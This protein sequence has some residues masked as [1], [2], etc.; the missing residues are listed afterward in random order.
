MISKTVSLSE[1]TRSNT[2]VRFGIDNTPNETQKMALADTA[3]H[4]VDAVRKQFGETIDITSF[5]RSEKLNKKIGGAKGSQHTSGE[6]VDLDSRD[7]AMN[8]AIFNFVK[9][10]LTFDQLILEAPDEKGVPSWVHVSYVKHPKQ[11]RG[12]VLVYL[13][14]SKKYIPFG[15]FQ[16]GMK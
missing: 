9:D 1:A 10:N 14:S 6:A 7:N 16:V 13:A 12:Q 4:V 3:I 5:F 8:L 15:E 2:A 11:N